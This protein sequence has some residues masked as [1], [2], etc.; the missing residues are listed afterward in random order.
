MEMR[1]ERFCFSM[2]KKLFF[3]SFFLLF[4][5]FFWKKL[6]KYPLLLFVLKNVRFSLCNINFSFERSSIFILLWI[7]IF[8][9][10]RCIWASGMVDICGLINSSHMYFLILL[11]IHRSHQTWVDILS[12]NI[13]DLQR[14]K[15]TNFSV[16]LPSIYFGFTLLNLRG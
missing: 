12:M 14:C 3:L 8:L 5:L 15:T 9:H 1:N 11:R 2:H 4:F 10:K 16:W 6:C 7:W 13:C